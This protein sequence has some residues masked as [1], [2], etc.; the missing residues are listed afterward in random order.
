MPLVLQLLCFDS[1]ALCSIKLLSTFLVEEN[2]LIFLYPDLILNM[3]DKIYP[4]INGKL[5]FFYLSRVNR[6]KKTMKLSRALSDLVK[7]TKSVGIH[8]VETESRLN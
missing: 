5:F 3:K 7:Y 4:L 2:L 8:D 1:E 6:Q